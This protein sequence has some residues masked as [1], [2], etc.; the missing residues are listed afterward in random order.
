MLASFLHFNKISPSISLTEG[1]SKVSFKP[2]I[3]NGQN[4]SHSLFLNI[5]DYQILILSEF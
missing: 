1:H 3:I 2:N 5:C 4:P